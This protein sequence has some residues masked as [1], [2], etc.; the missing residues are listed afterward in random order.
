[1]IYATFGGKCLPVRLRKNWPTFPIILL[2]KGGLNYA[3]LCAV[4]FSGPGP[5]ILICGCN[6]LLLML[7]GT[8]G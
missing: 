7:L 2:S 4:F 1:M 8:K 5:G 6:L 3:L